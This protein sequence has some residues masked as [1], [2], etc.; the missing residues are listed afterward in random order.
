MNKKVLITS[1]KHRIAP[2]FDVATEFLV[3]F[4]K[5][6]EFVIDKSVNIDETEFFLRI[7]KIKK[8]N[9]EVV[10]C[11]AISKPYFLALTSLNIEVIPFIA[12]DVDEVINAYI[13]GKVEGRDFIMPGCFRYRRNI[14][15]RWLMI[16][17]GGGRGQ[18][19]GRGQGGGG[20]GMGGGRMRG[21]V[22]G[23]CI[24]PKCGHKEEHYRGQPCFEKLCPKCNTPLVRE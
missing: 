17:Q 2:V 3:V 15:R 10:L 14:L 23:R 11:G 24:C 7:L 12:G 16:G 13:A 9:P 21:S 18:G 8:V 4:V 20:R 6:K 19:R 5:G 1:W 22:D